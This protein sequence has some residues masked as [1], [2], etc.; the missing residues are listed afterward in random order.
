MRETT[1][2]FESLGYRPFGVTGVVEVESADGVVRVGR[3]LGSGQFY[4]GS[5]ERFEVSWSEVTVEAGGEVQ[6]GGDL[7]SVPVSTYGSNGYPTWK[8][9]EKEV[10]QEVAVFPSPVVGV[11]YEVL[12]SFSV[13]PQQSPQVLVTNDGGSFT[14]PRFTEVAIETWSEE[15]GRN[16][17][18]RVSLVRLRSVMVGR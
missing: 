1:G 4:S 12:D 2:T 11:G 3:D 9:V 18:S 14:V 8:Q 13:S 16:V 7:R 15:S 10:S 6:L 5:V 17:F